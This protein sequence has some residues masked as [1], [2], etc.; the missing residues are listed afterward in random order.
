MNGKLSQ[1]AHTE[2]NKQQIIVLKYF[3][4]GQMSTFGGKGMLTVLVPN[5][6][7]SVAQH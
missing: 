3:D 2:S 7:S 4:L 1:M 5:C 6:D